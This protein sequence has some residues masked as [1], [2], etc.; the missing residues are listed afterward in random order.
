MKKIQTQKHS[1]SLN[2]HTIDSLT[3]L[4]FVIEIS[5]DKTSAPKFVFD[6]YKYEHFGNY[7]RIE[8][9]EWYLYR[10]WQQAFD[11]A[12]EELTHLKLI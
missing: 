7:E 10:T 5:L 4:G 6:I 9:R 1:M 2:N 12:V 3:K 11:A 8:V